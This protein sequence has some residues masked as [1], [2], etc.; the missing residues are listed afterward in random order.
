MRRVFTPGSCESFGRTYAVSRSS[1]DSN[2]AAME[3]LAGPGRIHLSNC[4]SS[5]TTQMQSSTDNSTFSNMSNGDA[6]TSGTYVR[7]KSTVTVTGTSTWAG[8][9][10]FYLCYNASTTL[11][12]CDSTGTSNPTGTTLTQVGGDVAVCNTGGTCSPSNGPTATSASTQ[13]SASGSY[14]WAA[15][16]TSTSPT[17][18]PDATATTTECFSATSPTSIATNPWFYPQDR[19]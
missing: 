13:L 18:L 19:P 9:V 3:D 12:G 17:G 10:D 15:E 6:L 11:T 16:F 1:G 4:E 8:N 2:T 5:A 14:C 7:D